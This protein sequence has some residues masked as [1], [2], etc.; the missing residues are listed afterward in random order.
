ME[1]LQSQF[2]DVK[3]DFT[4]IKNEGEKKNCCFL[5]GVL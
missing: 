2:V 5:T 3:F 1:G 4:A